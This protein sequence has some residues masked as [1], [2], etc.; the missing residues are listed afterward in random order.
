MVKMISYQKFGLEIFVT[1]FLFLML[2]FRHSQGTENNFFVELTY[3]GNKLLKYFQ[4]FIHTIHNESG[5]SLRIFTIFL[6]YVSLPCELICSHWQDLYKSCLSSLKES[7]KKK[8]KYFQNC[9][10]HTQKSVYELIFLF[11]Q[12]FYPREKDSISLSFTSIFPS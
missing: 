2:D 7:N 3:G 8:K 11:I 5:T 4:G 1:F 6:Q 12:P 10:W 9:I